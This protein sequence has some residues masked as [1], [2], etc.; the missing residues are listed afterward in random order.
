MRALP[1]GGIPTTLCFGSGGIWGYLSDWRAYTGVWIHF[2]FRKSIG[3]NNFF[4]FLGNGSDITALKDFVSIMNMMETRN[5]VEDCFTITPRDVL[6]G[7]KWNEGVG[8]GAEDRKPELN[9]WVDDPS[10]SDVVWVS[11][12]GQEPQELSLEWISL[13][14]GQMA[15]FNCNCGY[16]SAKLYLP[17]GGAQFG[18][19]RCLKLRYRGSI[20]NPRSVVGQAIHKYSRMNK[21]ADIRANI[22]R[23][24]YKGEYTKRYKRFLK[25]CS[26]EALTGNAESLLNIIKTQ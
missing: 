6:R 4:N 21:L 18:C 5:M 16:R 15:Y 11:V 17:P 9:C 20:I 26:D 8:T 13:T 24:F 12:K 22:S 7:L 23:I 25:R 3:L 14:Y 10:D 19:R 2:C 1:G